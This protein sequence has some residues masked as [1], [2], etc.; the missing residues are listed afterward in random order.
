MGARVAHESTR[1]PAETKTIHPVLSGPGR[2]LEPGVRGAMEQRFGHDFSGVRV[3]TDA[4]ASA[5]AHAL[6]ASAYTVGSNVVFGHSRYRPDSGDGR[7]LLAHELAHTVQQSASPA[8]LSGG[9]L[10]VEPPGTGHERAAETAA[11]NAAPRPTLAP[12]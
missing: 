1:R 4:S 8:A 12:T 5:S 2:P 9:Q 10:K 3:H 11:T 6:G 7:R